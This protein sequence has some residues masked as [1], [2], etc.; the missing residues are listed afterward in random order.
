[1][2]LKDSVVHP[3]CHSGLV[4]SHAL[5]G[6]DRILTLAPAFQEKKLQAIF[7]KCF[8]VYKAFSC[9]IS[10]P[11]SKSVHPINFYLM[12]MLLGNLTPRNESSVTPVFCYGIF[13]SATF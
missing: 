5:G 1:M 3:V 4:H 11:H 2:H 12:S 13:C 7:R 10:Y 6:Q 8:A 9:R